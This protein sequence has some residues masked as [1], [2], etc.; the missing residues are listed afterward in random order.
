MLRHA[1]AVA[2]LA[3]APALADPTTIIFKVSDSQDTYVTDINAAG[4]V[5]GNYYVNGAYGYVRHT[6]G[7]L[8]SLA[9][10]RGNVVGMNDRGD[11][12]G[13]LNFRG[14][15]RTADG[16]FR[17]IK[18]PDVSIYLAGVNNDGAVAGHTSDRDSHTQGFMFTA[19]R[20]YEFFDLPDFSSVRAVNN[21]GMIAGTVITISGEYVF[22]RE[23]DGTL[24]TFTH[25]GSKPFKDVAAMNDAGVMT[26]NLGSVNGS[27][28]YREP[29]VLT[30]DGI[31]KLFGVRPGHETIAR[32]INA[33][34]VVV[35]YYTLDHL[36][37]GFARAADGTITS[38]DCPGATGT[39]A[40]AI[41]DSGVIAG[42]CW[43]A[44][45]GTSGFIRIP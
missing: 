43:D 1:I 6:D 39:R 42:T 19:S 45:N 9:P 36:T 44:A 18:R 8:E 25:W 30:P 4:E 37:H 40:E 38:F 26:G 32:D 33:S 17:K 14:F 20:R 31:L 34:G 5:I 29:F 16:T 7:S 21:S 12:V 11:V 35:G 15:L 2:L 41:N 3:A 13:N 10:H 22:L 24:K 23:A 27:E 28:L